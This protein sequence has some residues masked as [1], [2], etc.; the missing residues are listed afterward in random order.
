MSLTKP[1][2]D[3]D[4]PAVSGRWRLALPLAGIVLAALNLRG[5]ITSVGPLIGDVRDDLH[6]S[7]A[8]VGLLTTAPLLAFGLIAPLAPPLARRVGAERA[9][10]GC[11]LLLGS[12]LLLRV[13][14]PTALLFAGTLLVGCAIAIGNVLLP[15]L[16]KQ[17]FPTRAA[18]MTGV[19][20]IALGIGA[21]V[22]AA[23]AIPLERWS[24]GSWRT[25]LAVWALPA[26]LAALAWLPAVRSSSRP[27]M[28][29]DAPKQPVPRLWRDR[30]AWQVSAF[31]AI[32]SLLFYTSIAWLPQILRD[33]GFSSAHAGALL[34]LMV[35]LGLPGGFLAA[36]AI[37]RSS[38]QRAIGVACVGLSTASLLGLL[39][40]RGT[41]AP[42]WC[43]LLGFALGA[44]FTLVLTLMVLR[45]PDA[46]HAAALAGMAQLVG[47]V[48]AALGPIGVGALHDATGSWT[49]ALVVLVALTLPELLAALG[50]GRPRYVRTSGA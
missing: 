37:H 13:L 18:L 48:V 23:L 4:S 38:D 42:L 47:Y 49:P 35:T 11:L 43:A 17:R 27:R 39:V 21:S 32:Q 19:Y 36:L 44:G 8:A 50:A 20:S 6:L 9:L 15:A 25:S 10:L 31:M 30:I 2:S 14:P 3:A 29:E 45:A 33:A 16:V 41:L 1:A 28:D 34:S 5:P 46:P 12:G 7:G 22:A 40:L 24:G 26:L